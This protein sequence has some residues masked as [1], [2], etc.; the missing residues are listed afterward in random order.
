MAKVTSLRKYKLGEEP[1][2][3]P[4]I[5]A[6]TPGERMQLVWELTKTAWLFHDPAALAAGFRRDVARV[7]RRER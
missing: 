2:V 1:E 6:M 5:L 3:D 7:V 4:E